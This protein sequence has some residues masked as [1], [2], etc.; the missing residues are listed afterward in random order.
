MKKLK[1]VKYHTFIF[2]L[3]IHIKSL[4]DSFL[5]GFLLLNVFEAVVL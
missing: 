1:G 2:C 5:T 3:Y 4:H